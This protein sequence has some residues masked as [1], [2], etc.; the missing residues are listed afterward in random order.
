M[1]RFLIVSALTAGMVFIGAESLWAAGPTLEDLSGPEGYS[2]A[3]KILILLTLMHPRHD[4][5]SLLLHNWSGIILLH[6]ITTV[7]FFL[8]F[9]IIH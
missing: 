6:L 3:I 4:L 8:T 2:S 1:R 5:T 9:L 7:L